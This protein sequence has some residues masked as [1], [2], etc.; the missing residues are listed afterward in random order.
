LIFLQASYPVS[1][2]RRR[3]NWLER[4]YKEQQRRLSHAFEHADV[5]VDT[6][7]LTVEQVL[8]EVLAFLRKHAL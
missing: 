5:V 3:L 8:E 2:G 6:D 1:S 4:D 7:S